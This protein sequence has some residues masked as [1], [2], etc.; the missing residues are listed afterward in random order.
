VLKAGILGLGS[1][2][3]QRASPFRP[4][5]SSVGAHP[6]TDT[7]GIWNSSGTWKKQA[8]NLRKHKVS[9]REEATVFGDAL[10]LLREILTNP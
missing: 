5:T 1:F 4:F 2:E 6:K 7:L 3:K 10:R 8:D 9:F